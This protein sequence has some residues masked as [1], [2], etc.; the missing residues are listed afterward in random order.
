MHS[1]SS[2]RQSYSSGFSL[3]ELMVAVT[4]GL[5]LM[6]G[7]ATIFVDN[8]RARN[9]L[10]RAT[11]Q[12][13]NG[14]YVLQVLSNDLRM[15][16]YLG[17]FDPTVLPLPTTL[18]DPCQTAL[19]ELKTQLPLQVQGYDDITSSPLNCLSDVRNGTDVLVVRRVSSCATG[20][21]DCDPMVAGMPYFQAALCD[22][23]NELGSSDA[24][25]HY[26]LE[27]NSM[28]LNR[29][30]RDCVTLAKTRRY[31]VEIYFIAANG[32]RP[33]SIPSLNRAE[34]GPNGFSIVPLVDGIDNMQIEYGIDTNNDG[35]PDLYS[36]NPGAFNSCQGTPC[37]I[38][39]W[40][41]VVATKLHVLARTTEKS[42]EYIDTKTYFLGNKADGSPYSIGPLND[43]FKRHAYQSTVRLLN[44]AGRRET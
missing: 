37:E 28:Q 26:A 34:L 4:I 20:D 7:L 15:A 21:T 6:V 29:H 16:G 38:T 24:S 11:R 32:G 36:A 42:A 27:T 17:E 31:M 22:K 43:G 9:E 10:E 25:N 13:E 41:N 35:S 33:E 18:P 19:A 40:S 39:N 12:N 14:R 2:L 23:F 1:V 44:P 5:L 3:V 30:Q 8:S